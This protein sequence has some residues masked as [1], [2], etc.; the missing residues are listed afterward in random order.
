MQYDVIHLDRTTNPAEGTFDFRLAENLSDP[1][2]S[3]VLEFKAVG[4]SNEENLAVGINGR[5]TDTDRVQRRR[6]DDGGY[7]LHS[8]RLEPG[9]V[10]FGDN[11]LTVRLA[12]A[13][14]KDGAVR[15]EEVNV[16]IEVNAR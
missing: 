10:R 1:Q 9:D 7:V 15:I 2:V 6:S 3:A 11:R 14:G 12:K 16:R 4:M 13:A 5:A 8:V